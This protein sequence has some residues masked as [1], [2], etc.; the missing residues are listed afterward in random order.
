MAE[1]SE[2]T[3][4][5]IVAARAAFERRAWRDAF[6]A[7]ERADAQQPLALPEL[8]LLWSSASLCGELSSAFAALERIYHEHSASQPASAARAAFWLG[9]RLMHMGEASRAGGWL[10]RAER[11]VEKI[12]PCVEA[13]YVQLPRVRQHFLAQQYPDALE[14]ATQVVAIAERFGDVELGSFARNLQGRILIRQGALEAGLR[15]HDEAML[16]VTAGEVS[17]SI[18]G[19]IYCS[20]IDSCS[21]V[22][23]MDRVREWTKALDAWC[24]AQPQLR[25]FTGECM[26]CRAEVMQLG[27]LWRDA[28]DEAEQAAERLLELGPH[29]TGQAIYLQG[30]ILRLR[31]ELEQAEERYRQAS[32]VGR[33]PQPGLAL[34][35]LA[36]GRTDLALQ[37]LRSAC[38]AASQAQQRVR[39]LPAYIEVAAAAGAADEAERAA[40]ELERIAESFGTELVRALAAHGRADVA[41]SSGDASAALVSSRRA[42]ELLVTLDAPYLAAKARVLVA[43]A[44]QA[45]DD[46]ESALLAI[47]AARAAFE[48]LGA[49]ADV[50]AVDALIARA[51]GASGAGAGGLSARELEV[52]RLVAAGKTNKLIAR[53]LCLSEKTIDRH[54]SNIL[55]KLGVPT[56]A[57]ATAFAYEHKLL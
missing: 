25:A 12:G 9:F 13:G 38:S 14:V 31:G 49:S 27:G 23:A 55:A 52:L 10:S 34:L 48:Q 26:V 24:R 32:Q 51:G 8:W 50:A 6:G 43:C 5:A 46:V 3:T 47:A 17:A 15:L 18:T 39:L 40:C 44:C 41:L 56:R 30:D 54:V 33:D 42:C 37:A 19:L 7:F 2:S 28:L 57:G 36:Q 11:L 16:A 53:E 29:A 4:N 21:G 22:L 35:R 20:A 1:L 45:L